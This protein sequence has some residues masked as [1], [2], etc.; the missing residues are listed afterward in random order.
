M[1]VDCVVSR[2]CCVREKD[3]ERQRKHRERRGKRTFTKKKSIHAQK[4]KKKRAIG[5]C[6]TRSKKKHYCIQTYIPPIRPTHQ[7]ITHQPTILNDHTHLTHTC[8]THTTCS[9]SLE[10]RR[11]H[12]A[13]LDFDKQVWCSGSGVDGGEGKATHLEVGGCARVCGGACGSRGGHGRAGGGGGGDRWL[14]C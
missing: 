5:T 6:H 14:L 7:I 1:C 3:R 12:C 13:V 4:K 2:V 11:P 8:D 9:L 10:E